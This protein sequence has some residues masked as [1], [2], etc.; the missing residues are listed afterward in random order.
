MSPLGSSASN[1]FW[2][3]LV[4]CTQI[5]IF[6]AT[7]CVLVPHGPFLFWC[8]VIPVSGTTSGGVW[9]FITLLWKMI[10]LQAPSNPRTWKDICSELLPLKPVGQTRS[11]A[12]DDSKAG[13][14]KGL[15]VFATLFYIEQHKTTVWSFLLHQ[16]A[17]YFET[18]GD[19]SII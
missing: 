17:L 6:L 18:S 2:Y 12:W 16:F 13:I 15:M 11:F 4:A 3:R 8:W 5:W 10:E 19:I 7:V 9:E 1:Y 14:H